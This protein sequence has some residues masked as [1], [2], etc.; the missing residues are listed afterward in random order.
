[1]GAS[2]APV[3]AEQTTSLLHLREAADLVTQ[4][5][6]TVAASTSTL[7]GNSECI[8]LTC[9]QS[10]CSISIPTGVQ[11]LRIPIYQVNYKPVVH[12]S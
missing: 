9:K 1:M 11:Q 3:V 6:S 5:F 12:G 10:D 8:S 7:S 4:A 2:N